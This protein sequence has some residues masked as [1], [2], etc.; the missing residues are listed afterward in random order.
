MLYEFGTLSNINCKTVVARFMI[1]LFC[2][3][4][5]SL[6]VIIVLR[7]DML[8]V[9]NCHSGWQTRIGHVIV[10]SMAAS[11]SGKSSNMSAVDWC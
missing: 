10:K 5:N 2:T 9:L 3:L 1:S 7:L 6:N 4:Y 8:V 11:G